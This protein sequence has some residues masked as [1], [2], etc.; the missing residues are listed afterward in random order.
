MPSSPS[1]TTSFG[2]R[3]L[4]SRPTVQETRRR[5]L[6]AL[7]QKR[8][9]PNISLTEV[10]RRS[11]TSVGSIR[12]Y[13]DDVLI[14]GRGRLGLSARDTLPRDMRFLTE[15]GEIILRIRN[16]RYS[17]WLG[18]YYNDLSKY[19]NTGEASGLAKYA[20]RT[21][22]VRGQTYRFVTDERTLNR[23][24]RAGAMHFLDI[25]AVDVS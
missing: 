3:R 15:R 23:L 24:A 8:K 18:E 21:I 5:V 7:A 25:Y 2:R 10:A 13:A 1:R 19:L 16:S 12:R 22:K 20:K 4:I 11:R 6:E 9:H 14:T 17:S